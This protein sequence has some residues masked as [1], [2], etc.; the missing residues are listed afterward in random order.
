VS[1]M[2]GYKVCQGIHGTVIPVEPDRQYETRVA[3]NSNGELKI[4]CEA[5]LIN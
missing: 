1:G 4:Y 5:D 3:Y 2:S